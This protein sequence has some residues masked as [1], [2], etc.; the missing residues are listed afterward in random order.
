[1]HFDACSASC[2]I[3]IFVKYLYISK[4]DVDIDSYIENREEGS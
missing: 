3:C 4:S 2:H 1:M